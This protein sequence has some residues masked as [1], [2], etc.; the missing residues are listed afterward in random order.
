V[1]T[2]IPAVAGYDRKGIAVYQDVRFRTTPRLTLYGRLTFFDTDDFATAIYEYENDVAGV[3]ANSVLYGKGTR[4]YVVATYRMGTRFDVA[5]K[6]WQLY[7][8][9]LKSIGSGGDAI[10]GNV[11]S[12]WTTSISMHL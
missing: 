10:S 6:F 7:R 5:V 4:W 3:F 8:D 2:D 11:L 12:K 9:D 1:W